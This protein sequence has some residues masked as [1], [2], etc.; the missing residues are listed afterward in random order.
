MITGKQRPSLLDKLWEMAPK[1]TSREKKF[2]REIHVIPKSLK[3]LFIDLYLKQAVSEFICKCFVRIRMYLYVSVCISLVYLLSVCVCMYVTQCVCID[4]YVCV[5]VCMCRYMY[6]YVCIC[7]YLHALHG[8]APCYAG[9]TATSPKHLFMG[10]HPAGATQGTPG[11]VR[12]HLI[13]PLASHA[14]T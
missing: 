4:M 8:L 12:K 11:H 5:P 13:R 7:M 14:E 9:T 1:T 6:V 3:H 10:P 2:V